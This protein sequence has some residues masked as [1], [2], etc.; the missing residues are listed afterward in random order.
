MFSLIIPYHN[1]S[2][3]L[4][5][6]LR[7]L[8]DCSIKPAQ[9]ILVDNGS[10]DNSYEICAAFADAHPELN[11]LLLVESKK[12]ACA[13]RNKGLA[14]VTSE[15]VYFFD[16]DDELSPDFF[17][18]V[19]RHL[20]QLLTEPDMVACQTV[21]YFADGK[22]QPRAVHFSD[23]AI[24]Q[25]LSG[26][27]A[28]QG[29]FFRTEFIRRIGGWNENLPRWNDWELGIRVL[30]S[31]TNVTWLKDKPY[32]KIYEHT[33]SITG[34]DFSSSATSLLKALNAAYQLSTDK[35][36]KFAL[37][38]RSYILAGFFYREHSKINAIAAKTFAV[39]VLTDIHSKFAIFV[40]RCLYKYVC[41]GGRG[42]W[43]FALKATRM[44]HFS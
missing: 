30:L 15:W 6:T 23:S 14:H 3:F 19:V 10:N 44:L 11:V 41:V 31:N 16:S 24:D 32:H 34:D 7:S 28:T 26:Q 20:S 21:R 43:Y 5:R 9:L 12:G 25:L 29:M 33:E 22:C 27:L 38:C 17:G 1:R 4:P 37:A 39:K 2:G 18:N 8:L 35:Q 40:A 42:A 36:Y 13:A